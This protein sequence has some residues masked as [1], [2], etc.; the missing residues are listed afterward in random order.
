MLQ[1]IESS[2]EARESERIDRRAYNCKF[3]DN[4]ERRC[5]K[6]KVHTNKKVIEENN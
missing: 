5:F 1:L 3:K 4:C 2:I 6:T